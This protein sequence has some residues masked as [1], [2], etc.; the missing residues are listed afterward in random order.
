MNGPTKIQPRQSFRVFRRTGGRVGGT[1][2]AVTD[3]IVISLPL[4]KEPPD[5]YVNIPAVGS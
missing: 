3:A 4:W 2:T 5:V 1:V